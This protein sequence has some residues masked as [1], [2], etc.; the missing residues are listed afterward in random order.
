M[1]HSDYIKSPGECYGSGP[2]ILTK[3]AVDTNIVQG[4]KRGLLLTMLAFFAVMIVRGFIQ[5]ATPI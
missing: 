4:D 5:Y 3:I 1:S 2:S